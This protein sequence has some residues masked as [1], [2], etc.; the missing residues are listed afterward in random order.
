MINPE[1]EERRLNLPV[2][3]LSKE[4]EENQMQLILLNKL[5]I[6]LAQASLS[7]IMNPSHYYWQCWIFDYVY[8]F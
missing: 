2:L 3:R 6:N 8:I 7:S 4:E 1:K 5:E